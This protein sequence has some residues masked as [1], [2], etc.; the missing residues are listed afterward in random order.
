MMV[1]GLRSWNQLSITEKLYIKQCALVQFGNRMHYPKPNF[2]STR[3][4]D[5]AIVSVLSG[6]PIRKT[7]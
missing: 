2:Y 3:L 6:R 7:W 1:K 4:T 5:I